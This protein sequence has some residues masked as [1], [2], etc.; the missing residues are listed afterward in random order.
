MI[1]RNFL[2]GILVLCVCGLTAQADS[3]AKSFA[4]TI[5]AYDLR[6]NLN[7]IA[8]PSTEGRETGTPGLRRA[9]DYII[10]KFGLFGVQ[11]VAGSG[12][13]YQSFEYKR[14]V[15][16]DVLMYDSLR[17]YEFLKDF[18]V[19]PDTRNGLVYKKQVVFMG[20]GI[21]DERY[22]DFAKDTNLADKIV[23]I[24]NDEPR[25]KNKYLLSGSSAHSE[26]YH[27][28][29]RRMEAIIKC[30]PAA[31]II[32]DD[33]FYSRIGSMSKILTTNSSPAL[34]ETINPINFPILF[35]NKS[36]AGKLLGLDSAKLE[37]MIRR[38][39]RKKKP[40][41]YFSNNRVSLE[42]DRIE[43]LPTSENVIGYVEGSDL[44]D[45]YII[46]S[47]HYDHLGKHKGKIYFGAD[48]DGSGTVS[49]IEIAEAFAIAKRAGHGPR[50]SILF[51]A[52]SGE[53]KGLLGSAFYVKHPLVPLS[54]MVL[55]LNIDMIGRVDSTY[56]ALQNPN[57][58][59]PIGSNK[60]SSA[61]KPLLEKC[62][63]NYT[64]LE[65]NYRYD[66]PADKNKFYSRS[67]HYNFAKNDIPVIFFF[68]GTHADYHKPT[69]T[70]DKINFEKMETI[71]RLVFYVAWTSANQTERLKIDLK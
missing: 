28:M 52:F 10:S 23:I 17:K 63:T 27:N 15:K 35:T 5:T 36:V 65:L 59:Y 31:V 24:L 34:L 11:Q 51:C 50:R 1:K 25:A 22:N 42:V 60:L 57:Y 18:F 45:E 49:L 56:T 13:Y 44:K 8:S 67:D 26:W 38:S 12:T 64:N 46:I 47:A 37:R 58:V 7:F 66:D 6:D 71:A 21:R 16:R 30:Q 53:E 33:E 40:V 70:I 68:N 14:D 61:L 48:D 9:G 32:I 55:D 69:D 39:E 41:H 19:Q 3:L 4:S 62:N 29:S 2:T 20:F 54:Q 43:T